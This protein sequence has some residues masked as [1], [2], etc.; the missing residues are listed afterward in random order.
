[1]PQATAC[2]RSTHLAGPGQSHWNGQSWSRP[3]HHTHGSWHLHPA[4]HSRWDPHHASPRHQSRP[5]S[6][7]CLSQAPVLTSCTPSSTTG[8]MRNAA[9]SSAISSPPWN[10]ATANSSSTSSW[11]RTGALTRR[12]RDSIGWWW[13]SCRRASA[14]KR[15][16]PT[17]CR[18][19]G[20]PSWAF[21]PIV[22]ERR[23]WSRRSSLRCWMTIC[24]FRASCTI[25]RR[26]PQIS[27]PKL[28]RAEVNKGSA[29]WILSDSDREHPSKGS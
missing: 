25:K 1:M 22:R 23:A 26:N 11:S 28:S 19:W 15:T 18:V 20:W 24:N 21:G 10:P 14:R 27:V 8:P 16:G 3:A 5:W 6:W 4:A 17:C 9:T 2:A 13:R 29:I 7:E 12:R